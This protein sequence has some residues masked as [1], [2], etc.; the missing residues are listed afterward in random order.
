[1]FKKDN[2]DVKLGYLEHNVSFSFIKKAC[3]KKDRL[4]KNLNQPGWNLKLDSLESS[5]EVY[6][7]WG[8][9]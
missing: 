6:N 4:K 8:Y 7:H 5:C 9:I 1:M 2:W 3:N